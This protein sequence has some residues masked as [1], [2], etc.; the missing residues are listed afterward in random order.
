MNVSNLGITIGCSAAIGYVV[1][2]HRQSADS[3]LGGVILSAVSL[4]IV[5]SSDAL[6]N[7]LGKS[8]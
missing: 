5:P 7:I 8:L 6:M 1:D 4:L 3:A 2:S